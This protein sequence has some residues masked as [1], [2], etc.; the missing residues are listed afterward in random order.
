[1]SF[2]LNVTMICMY[3]F[4][5]CILKCGGNVLY[6]I[7]YGYHFIRNHRTLMATEA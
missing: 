1:M 4:V 2:S 7:I 5:F 3:T 6:Y